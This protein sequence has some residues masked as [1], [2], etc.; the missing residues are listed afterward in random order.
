MGKVFPKMR[1]A[2]GVRELLDHEENH[3]SVFCFFKYTSLKNRIVSSSIRKGS[4][5]SEPLVVNAEIRLI[6]LRVLA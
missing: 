4:S 3:A 2:Q 6:A 1:P 5:Q